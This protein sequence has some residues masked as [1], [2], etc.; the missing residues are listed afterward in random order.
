MSRPARVYT[1]SKPAGRVFQRIQC[2]WLSADL[3]SLNK[4]SHDTVV[5]KVEASRFFGSRALLTVLDK[6]EMWSIINRFEIA[7][8]RCCHKAAPS[9]TIYAKAVNFV[10]DRSYKRVS[11]QSLAILRPSHRDDK[12][13]DED[14]EFENYAAIIVLVVFVFDADTSIDT[15]FM[16]R[17]KLYWYTLMGLKMHCSFAPDS[18]SLLFSFGGVVRHL[19]GL[20][21]YGRAFLCSFED[22]PKKSRK[23]SMSTRLKKTISPLNNTWA[24]NQFAQELSELGAMIRP[25]NFH[26]FIQ[27]SS[28]TKILAFEYQG[29]LPWWA[30][31]LESRDPQ[32]WMRINFEAMFKGDCLFKGF[33]LLSDRE[34]LELYV[35]DKHATLSVVRFMINSPEIAH[36]RRVASIALTDTDKFPKFRVNMLEDGSTRVIGYGNTLLRSSDQQHFT[37]QVPDDAWPLVITVPGQCL[38]EW[39]SFS[40]NVEYS[41]SKASVEEKGKGGEDETR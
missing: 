13:Y 39:E 11:L 16:K 6:L 29:T 24:G 27:T 34:T 1:F 31:F 18:K 7:F 2:H 12:N 17:E 15:I 35:I 32:K 41:D 26:D 28:G 19:S 40:T 33:K 30:F 3:P 21:Y 22:S 25:I 20:Q 37:E 10:I 5:G 8:E 9:G 36:A 23:V 14:N 4:H 38:G